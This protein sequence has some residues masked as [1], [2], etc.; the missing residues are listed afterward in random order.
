MK[1][2]ALL[3]CLLL[4]NALRAE[5]TLTNAADVIR[6]LEQKQLG[7]RFHLNGTVAYVPHNPWNY[8]LLADGRLLRFVVG[9]WKKKVGTLRAGDNIEVN[10]TIV[11]YGPKHEISLASMKERHLGRGNPLFYSPCS[12]SE[13]LSRR[14]PHLIRVTGRVNSLFRD[15]LYPEW[16]FLSLGSESDSIYCITHSPPADGLVLPELVDCVISVSGLFEA[17]GAYRGGSQQPYVSFMSFADV[18]VLKTA[19]FWTTFRLILVV[20]LLIAVLI[21]FAIYCA[22]Q[23]KTDNARLLE[24]TRLATELHDYMAQ[25]ITAISYQITAAKQ[26]HG[27]DPET[28]LSHLCTADR[29]ISSCRTEIRRCLWDL[30]NEALNERDFSKAVRISLGPL[31]QGVHSSVTMNVPR[32][33]LDDAMAH[34]LLSVIRELVSNATNHGHAN[35]VTV[36]GILDGNR[37]TVT[38]RD[39][40]YGFS[41]NDSPGLEAGHFGLSGI[42]ERLHRYRGE[43]RIKSAPGE[44]TVVTVELQIKSV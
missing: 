42:R 29:M 36:S 43:V 19:P 40:G 24:R 44:G 3:I 7:T 38:V 22:I 12:V 28:S 6:A 23:R 9:E 35:R 10:G 11:T 1:L 26:T 17:D 33:R 15:P 37:L 5:N 20:F 18:N 13:L 2:F 30:K 39:N 31:L 16:I 8:R 27:S 25:D 34:N 32:T 41:V 14:S 4:S 21:A